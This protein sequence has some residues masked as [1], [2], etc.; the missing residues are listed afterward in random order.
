MS[1]GQPCR[2][3]TGGPFAG[4]SSAYPMFRTP[5]SI[6]FSDLNAVFVPGLIGLILGDC[7]SAEPIVASSDAA[8]VRTAAPKRRRRSRL[9]SSDIASLLSWSQASER[10][11]SRFHVD[12]LSPIEY[13]QANP[14]AMVA[15]LVI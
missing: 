10:Y 4:P 12:L 8:S 15:V 13:A 3:I 14:C 2:R 7:A 9:I 1:Y 6:C 11:S 5:A